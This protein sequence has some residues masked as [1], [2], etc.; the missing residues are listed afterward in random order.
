MPLSSLDVLVVVFY[1]IVIAFIA[2]RSRK[3]A[4]KSLENYFL[5]G[6]AM[7]GWMAGI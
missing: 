7:R 6:R 2:W 3:F 4:S 1:L 5:G